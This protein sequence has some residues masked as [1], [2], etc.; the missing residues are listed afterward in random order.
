[1]ADRTTAQPLPGYELLANEWCDRAL[2]FAPYELPERDLVGI[3]TK[4]I[5]I[6]AGRA[7]R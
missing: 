4:R 5:D 2:H 7:A 3:R 1:M 6:A